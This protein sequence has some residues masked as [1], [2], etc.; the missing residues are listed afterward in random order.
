MVNHEQSLSL[1]KHLTTAQGTLLEQA[2]K[3]V[4]MNKPPNRDFESVRNFIEDKRPLLEED[5]AFISEREDL[6]T[7][8]PGRETSFVDAFVERILQTCHCKPIQVHIPVST[9]EHGR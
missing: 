4:A 2:Q 3:L 5:A 7:L 6:I 9:P 8:R 1:S